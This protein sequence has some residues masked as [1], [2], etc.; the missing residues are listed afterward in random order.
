MTSRGRAWGWVA[1]LRDGGTTP[2]MAWTGSADPGPRAL[3][4][5]QQLELLRRINER[6]RPPAGLVDRVL[7]ASAPGRGRPDLELAG[8]EDVQRFGPRP[9]DPSALTAT[10]LLRVATGLIAQDLVATGPP[11]E[12]TAPRPRRRRRRYRLA[13]DPWLVAATR[14]ALVQEGRPPGGPR[15]FVHVLGTD[16]ASMLRDSWTT[17]A[18][19]EGGPPWP[20]FLARLQQRDRVARRVDLPAIA[21]RWRRT[22]GPIGVD[23]VLDLAEL[24]RLVGAR[25]SRQVVG[26]VSTAVAAHAAELARQV[27]A[28]LGLEVVPP[29]RAELLRGVLLPRLAGVPGR[30]VQVPHAQR[31]WVEEQATG[32]RGALLRGGYPVVGD[33][34]LLLPRWAA[35]P[36]GVGGPELGDVL[37]L[38][39]ELLLRP[40]TAEGVR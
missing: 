37:D 13:G 22:P 34:D 28:P 5:A 40:A 14:A 6:E 9:V 33:L 20:D 2:W 31:E 26:D 7:A 17:G 35:E 38:A 8:V 4:G 23:V 15:A 32:M 16:L 11:T 36:A 30:P 21:E 10:E 39:I 27:A 29:E 18:F 24:P 19:T 12:V 3:P 1:H 25:R